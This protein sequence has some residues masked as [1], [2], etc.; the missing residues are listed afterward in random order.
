MAVAREGLAKGRS[1]RNIWATHEGEMCCCWRTFYN[2]VDIGAAE[3]LINLNLPR[4]V[5]YRQR[6]RKKGEA[7]GCPIA[8]ENLVGRTYEDFLEP[9]EHVRANAVEMDTV[10][11]RKG[12]DKQVILTL[13]FRRTN[14]QIMVLL[15][16]KTSRNVVEALDSIEALCGD[17]F[18]DIFG[19]IQDAAVMNESATI[20][21]SALVKG[22]RMRDAEDALVS[23][24]GISWERAAAAVGVWPPT[25]FGRAS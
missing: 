7:A 23:A 3:E 16:E 19:V 21:L 15:P 20:A 4:K 25:W 11:G 9:P 5:K 8:R 14:F 6:K 22:G 1:I 17:T 18:K 2:Y 10:E 12:I 13:L 24:Y